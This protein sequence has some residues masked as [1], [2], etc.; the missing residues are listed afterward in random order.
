MLCPEPAPTLAH[1]HSTYPDRAT[2]HAMPATSLHPQ[3]VNVALM[4]EIAG[5]KQATDI[6]YQMV[7]DWLT[8]TQS[9]DLH[10]FSSPTYYWVQVNSLYMGYL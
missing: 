7:Q 4:G 3:Q 9:A 10:E 2:L 8:Y 1:D 5:N 6:G